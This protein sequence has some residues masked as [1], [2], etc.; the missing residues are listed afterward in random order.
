MKPYSYAKQ[1]NENKTSQIP[2]SKVEPNI[3]SISWSTR[4]IFWQHL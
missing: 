3:S 2:V 1:T 4:N